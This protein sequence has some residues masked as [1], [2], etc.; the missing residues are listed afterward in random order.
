MVEKMTLDKSK[1]HELALAA[2]EKAYGKG[3]VFRYGTD[4]PIA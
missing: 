3:S 2:I 4:K 1:A